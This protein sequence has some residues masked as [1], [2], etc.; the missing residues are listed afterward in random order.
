MGIESEVVTKL[1][2]EVCQKLE[3]RAIRLLQGNK[4]TLSGDDSPLTNIWDEICVQIQSEESV[5]WDV[6]E[7]T[8][9]AIAEGFV[10]ELPPHEREAIWLQTDEGIDGAY[11]DEED[12][13]PTAPVFNEDIVSYFLREYLYPTAG[14]WSNPR[15][16]AYLG[17]DG[18]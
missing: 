7:E 14:S 5:S 1:A 18:Y 6:Y 15:I 3:R 16:R 12:R 10:E 17:S 9:Q 11:E 8:V 4:F 2:S 13:E